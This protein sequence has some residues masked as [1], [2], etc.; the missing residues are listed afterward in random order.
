M[1]IVVSTAA[2]VYTAGVVFD[3]KVATIIDTLK[4]NPRLS[5]NFLNDIGGNSSGSGIWGKSVNLIDFIFGTA[6]V[7][8]IDNKIIISDINSI[9]NKK[10]V[11]ITNDKI[12]LISKKNLEKIDNNIENVRKDISNEE[13]DTSNSK[14]K[15]KRKK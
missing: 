13:K 6:I 9:I 10:K 5:A 4:K 8:I 7:K 12:T 1:A 3:I 14:K 15:R 2:L 11:E